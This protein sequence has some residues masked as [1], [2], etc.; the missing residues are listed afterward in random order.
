MPRSSW[1]APLAEA[2]GGGAPC[3]AAKSSNES[4]SGSRVMS[5][6]VSAASRQAFLAA[7]ASPVIS[8]I[9]SVT[10]SKSLSMA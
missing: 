7:P 9:L 5:T 2:P 6:C 8:L 10:V 3:S 4:W 1:Y